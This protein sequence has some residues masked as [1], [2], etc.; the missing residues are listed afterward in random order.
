VGRDDSV[1][2]NTIKQYEH[3]GYT[4][5]VQ[6]E[7]RVK[8]IN[9]KLSEREVYYHQARLRCVSREENGGSHPVFVLLGIDFLRPAA[10]FHF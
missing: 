10:L 8:W 6:H 1:I 4:D 7:D 2:E 5:Y 9:K 3:I